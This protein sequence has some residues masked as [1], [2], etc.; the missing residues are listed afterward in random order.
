MTSMPW[1][2]Q[3]SVRT[4]LWWFGENKSYDGARSLLMSWHQRSIRRSTWRWGKGRLLK[5]IKITIFFFLIWRRHGFYWCHQKLA[6]TK[7][8]SL[9]LVTALLG[10]LFNYP[11]AK[12]HHFQQLSLDLIALWLMSQWN[13]L[14]YSVPRHL[15]C[16]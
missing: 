6:Y 16:K 14:T 2:E 7:N 4:V 13:E 10:L 11:E 15:Y 12:S 9:F 3:A 1:L 5:R 8:W